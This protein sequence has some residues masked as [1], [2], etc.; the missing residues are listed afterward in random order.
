MLT[1]SSGDGLIYNV[2]RS[3]MLAATFNWSAADKTIVLA[4]TD[5]APD[6]NH[7]TLADIPGSLEAGYSGPMP[8]LFI[9]PKG[10]AGSAITPM[11]WLGA[12]ALKPIGAAIIVRHLNNILNDPNQANFELVACLTTFIGGPIFPDGS[13]FSL[14]FDQSNGQQGWFRP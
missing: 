6:E 3:R 10:W 5:Y 9:S 2:T 12:L 14:T 4:S 7:R 13:P 1:A 8:G 11:A